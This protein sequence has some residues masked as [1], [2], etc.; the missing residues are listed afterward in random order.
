MFR[1]LKLVFPAGLLMAGWMFYEKF[2]I[3]GL[4]NLNVKPRDGTSIGYGSTQHGLPPAEQV[5]DSIRIAS[6][7]IQVFGESKLSKPGV[8]DVLANVIRQFDVVAVQE[9][10]ANSQAVLP[11]FV[12]VINSGGMHYDFCIGPRLGRTSSK[13]Q[14]AF[15]YNA[16]RVELDRNAVYTINDPD[17]LLHREPLVASFR[18][19]G[20]A[21]Q[22]A[23]TFTLIN[24]HTDPDEVQR[25]VDVLADVYRVVRD[26]G[27]QEDDII[28]L[29]DLNADDQHLG[30][31]GQVPYALAAISGVPSNTHGTQLYDNILFD[32]RATTEFTGRSGVFDL[33][34]AYN[35]SMEQALLVSDH[36]PVWAEFGAVEGGRPG[37][38]AR[39]PAVQ[40]R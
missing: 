5:G 3:A 26:D 2:E 33:M 19:R 37:Q 1:L 29:G 38:F 22:D 8:V 36:F 16:A 39:Q 9:V 23:F 28:L 40:S 24:I 31:L 14:Y 13:E 21:A 35:L 25:E 11:Q 32:Q 10:R 18:V 34:K 6:F 20:L 17:D 30:R 4:G 12:S 27:R 7:N 15:I